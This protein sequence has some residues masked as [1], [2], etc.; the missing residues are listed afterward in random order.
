[1]EDT[2]AIETKS[3]V[4]FVVHLEVVRILRVVKYV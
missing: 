1:M 4:W 2:D 3:D